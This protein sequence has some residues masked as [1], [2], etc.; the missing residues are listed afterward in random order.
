MLARTLAGLSLSIRIGVLTAGV[1]AAA[2]LILGTAAATLGKKADA[3][4]FLVY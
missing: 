1:S 4:D 3:G 2:A